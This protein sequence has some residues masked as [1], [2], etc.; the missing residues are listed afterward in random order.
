MKQQLTLGELIF[1][2]SRI[3]PKAD[4]Q[5]DFGGFHPTTIDSYRGFYEQLA[6]GFDSYKKCTVGEFLARCNQ[7]VGATVQGWKG[8]D[9]DVGS[10]TP[11]WV[12]NRGHSH[13]T[14]IIGVIDLGHTAIIETAYWE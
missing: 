3:D 13:S 14:A 12:A 2:L 11:M 10:R 9:Y 7:M 1:V 8:G 6:V 5:Y 4:I